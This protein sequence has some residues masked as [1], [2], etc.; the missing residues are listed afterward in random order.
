MTN[1]CSNH[2]VVTAGSAEAL[3][4]I[5]EVL[6][7][8]DG[9]F[10]FDKLMPMPEVLKGTLKGSWQDKHGNFVREG[11]NVYVDDKMKYVR[12]FTILEK[13]QIFM[14]P[15]RYRNWSDWQQA[16]W[17]V[18]RG[19]FDCNTIIPD[20]EGLRVEYTFDTPWAP[21][22]NTFW[23]GGFAGEVISWCREYLERHDFNDAYLIEVKDWSY[24]S[25]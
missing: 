6:E 14:I 7:D 16:N 12:P 8:D 1:W 9:Y 4:A 10:T 20:E 5:R 25:G 11:K 18:T 3:N 19:P 15:G 22:G 23:G 24:H 2:W 17:G 13:F 21:P